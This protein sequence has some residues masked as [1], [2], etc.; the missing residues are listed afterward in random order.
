MLDGVGGLSLQ[1]AQPAVLQELPEL[2]EADLLAGA[3]GDGLEALDVRDVDS[4]RR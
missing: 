3:E 4:R 2:H 1:V